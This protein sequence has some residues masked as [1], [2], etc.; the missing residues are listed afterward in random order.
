MDIIVTG[1]Y[2]NNAESQNLTLGLAERA[3][4]APSLVQRH[5]PR[6]AKSVS[7]DWQGGHSLFIQERAWRR[8]EIKSSL[9]HGHSSFPVLGEADSQQDNAPREFLRP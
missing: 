3:L 4:I 5:C 6:K 2:Y 8:G 1:L 9:S 7:C